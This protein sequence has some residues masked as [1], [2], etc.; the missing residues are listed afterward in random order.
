MAQHLRIFLCIYTVFKT[1]SFIL[2]TFSPFRLHMLGSKSCFQWFSHVFPF[3]FNQPH[4][5]SFA[6]NPSTKGDGL[7]QLHSDGF[8][9]H[10]PFA[11]T[12]VSLKLTTA[13]AMDIGLLR[14]STGCPYSKSMQIISKEWYICIY[15]YTANYIYLII[16]LQVAESL[17]FGRKKCIS[18]YDEVSFPLFPFW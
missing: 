13:Q 14:C 9:T 10:E 4:G 3:P 15:I 6:R 8:A 5:S 18:E 1:N 7:R 11:Q 16:H 12:Q 17:W 2:S